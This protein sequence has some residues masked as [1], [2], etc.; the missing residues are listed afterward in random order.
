MT[1]VEE[2][3]VTRRAD[4]NAAQDADSVYEFYNVFD[5]DLLGSGTDYTVNV[6]L[7]DR[8]GMEI[9]GWRTGFDIHVIRD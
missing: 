8:K 2:M 4:R 9:A 3:G 6:R 5:T 7:L 1:F